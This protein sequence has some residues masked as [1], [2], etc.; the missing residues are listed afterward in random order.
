MRKALAVLSGA[1]LTLAATTAVLVYQR[2]TG[3]GQA[4][5]AVEAPRGSG[6]IVIDWNKEVVHIVGT[7]GAQPATIHPTRSFA[8]VHAAIY[9]AVV[10]ITGGSPYLFSLSAP[11]GARPDAAAAEAGHD[12]LLALY[13]SMKAA[14]DQQLAGELAAIPDGKAKTQ[15]IEVGHLAAALMLVVRADDGSSVT[16]AP[17]PGGT[18]PG[19]WRPAPPTLAPA[20]FT[21]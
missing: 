19:D 20:V 1:V 11:A 13:P 8:I 4:Q 15:G 17:F 5:A 21:Q 18:Q 3:G 14:L 10:S 7:P 6:Q 16:P 9:D 2:A 12:S